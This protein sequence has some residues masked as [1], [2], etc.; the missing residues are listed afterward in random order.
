MNALKKRYSRHAEVDQHMV[1]ELDLYAE[2]EAAL[3]PQKQAILRNLQLK[4]KKGV[5]DAAKAAKLWGYWVEA[6]SKRYRKEWPG[7]EITKGTRDEVAK[8]LARRYPKGVE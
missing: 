8:E 5:Y 4:A 3:Y 7:V 6:A 1:E 2:N